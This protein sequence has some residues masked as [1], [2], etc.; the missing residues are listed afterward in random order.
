MQDRENPIAVICF[1]LWMLSLVPWLFILLLSGMAFD[2]GKTL[3][4][5]VFVGSVVSYPVMVGIA[6]FMRR[7]RPFLLLLPLLSIAAAFL[8]GIFH[9]VR[10]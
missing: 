6:G 4:A 5:Y 2:N 3:E 8:S 7:R 1:V 9:N 10:Y